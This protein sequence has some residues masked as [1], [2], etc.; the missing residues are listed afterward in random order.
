[1]GLSNLVTPVASPD[2]DDGQLGQ[3]DGSTDGGRHLFRALHSKTNMAIVVTDSNKGLTQNP[4]IKNE[5]IKKPS[6]LILSE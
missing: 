2:R 6:P 3:N 1:M 5:E 4:L